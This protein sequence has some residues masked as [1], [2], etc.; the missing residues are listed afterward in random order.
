VRILSALVLSLFGAMLGFSSTAIA[1]EP[2]PDQAVFVFAGRYVDAYIEQSLTPFSANYE[3]NFVLG[4]GYQQFV[5]EPLPALRLGAEIGMA[6]R[7]GTSISGEVWAG[8]VLRYDG[9]RL[10]ENLRV[11]PSLTV[12]LSAVTSPIGVEAERAQRRNGDPTLLFFMA[13]EISVSTLDNPDTELFYRLQHRSGAWGTLGGMAD[14][15]NAQ[16]IGLRH[17]F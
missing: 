16:V 3:D 12:G 2:A 8:P 7:G 11:S 10:G 5:L 4:G 13:P 9:F 17:R 15:A 6:L 14:G 1:Q